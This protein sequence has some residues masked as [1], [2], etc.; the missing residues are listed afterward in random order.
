MNKR[1]PRLQ[2]VALFVML[3]VVGSALALAALAVLWPLSPE[4]LLA[5]A[6]RPAT[7]ILD[8][9]GRVLYEILDPQTG[10]H[11]NIPLSEI[12]L[13]LRQA[14]IATEDA[15]FYS[16]P[17]VDVWA[18]ARAAYINLR[19]G[20]VL[21]GGSTI[22]QQVARTLLMSPEERSQRT[23]WRKLKESFLAYR[24][25]R[26]LSKDQVLEL[27]LNQI[28]YGNLAYGV[29]AAAQ[30]YFGKPARELDLAECALLAGLPQ[31]PS[32]YN[33]LTNPSAAR[34]RQRVVLGLMAKQGYITREQ[35]AE[36]ERETLHFAAAPFPIAAP[37]FVMYVRERL[38]AMLPED[39]LRAGGLRVYTTLDLDAQRAAEDAIRRHLAKLAERKPGEPD[40]NVRNAAVVALAPQ[41]GDI[42]AMVGS[43][44][45]FSA[46]IDGAVNAALA[47]RQP[48]SAIKP[49]TYAAA[50]ARDYSP[51]TMLVDTREAFTTKEGDPYVP[52]N[53]DL[54]YHGPVLLR[55]A[56]ACSYNLIAVKVLQHVGIDALVE[57]A[58]ALG[59][60]SLD[61]SE[62][63]GLALT[64][65]GGEV[66]LL[67]LTQ[68]YAAFANGGQ[69][70]QA[71]AILRVEDAQGRVIG[72][73]EP[74][75]PRQGVSPQVAFLISDVLSDNTARAPA[76]GE[77]SPLR[78]S[79][80]A[81]AKTG[82]TTDWRDNWT[83]GYTP[84]LAVGVW[85]GNADNSPMRDVSGITG[86]APIWHDVMEAILRGLPVANFAPPEGVVRVEICADSGLLPNPDCPHR[87][88][89]WFIQGREPTQ[90]CDWHR[91]VPIDRLSGLVAGP[92]CPP[93]FVERRVFTFW[94]AEALDWV[95]AQGLP[96]PPAAPCPLHPGGQAAAPEAQGL[97]LVS[98]DPNGVYRLSRALPAEV[99]A[100][101]VSA[102]PMGGV[103]LATVTFYVDG[104]IAGRV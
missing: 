36:A 80:P 4:G 40:H 28:Y 49:L 91:A 78:L 95:R 99:Q 103:G 34:E 9:N 8:R 96:E 11:R 35:A 63:W 41:T 33:P 68:A 58:R 37:H 77:D 13:Y 61:D 56:L 32:A 94:P 62:R 70:V 29:E 26:H 72:S 2:R 39:V 1:E 48:G 15:T 88:L 67:E 60:T 71:R 45:Y 84:N 52:L 30:T 53:Y 24:L 5:A 38:A 57:T 93:E 85:V 69:V 64:L 10:R 23:L 43:P 17:G 51:A 82:T 22:T 100:L 81:A 73:W 59:I 75:S 87:R 46:E 20:E 50:F 92:N 65:G 76:F 89:E 12:P 6:P 21:A 79:R 7:Q 66:S 90:V 102:R 74:A 47:L 86:A 44:D 3:T 98:P 31:S 25:A 16:N 55:Q 83:V 104:A 14:T 54:R 97:A 19:G 18:I 101:E 27:Y 42:L